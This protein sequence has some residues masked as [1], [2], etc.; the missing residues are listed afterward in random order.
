MLGNQIPKLSLKPF[1]DLT[2]LRICFERKTGWEKILPKCK[3]QHN[4]R[5]SG[6]WEHKR[7]M[8]D[9]CRGRAEVRRGSVDHTVLN[10]TD[11]YNFDYLRNISNF[12]MCSSVFLPKRAVLSWIAYF[13]LFKTFCITNSYLHIWISKLFRKNFIHL[14]GDLF[15]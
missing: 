7:L 2:N 1:N 12:W 10:I 14:F 15:L 3:P 5:C 11:V 13:F 8:G 9:G 4:F 6:F